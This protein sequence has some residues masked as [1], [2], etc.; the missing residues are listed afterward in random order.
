MLEL[1]T[2]TTWTWVV[3]AWHL[4]LDDRSAVDGACSLACVL[5]GSCTLSRV[6]QVV[7]LLVVS[8]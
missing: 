5:S 6:G 8:L 2:A 4:V 7:F 3:G 1:L